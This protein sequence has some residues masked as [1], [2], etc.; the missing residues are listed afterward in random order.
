MST[1]QFNN[2]TLP[3]QQKIVCTNV[4]YPTDDIYKIIEKV[5]EI[6]K[7]LYGIIILL[8]GNSRIAVLT[9]KQVPEKTIKTAYRIIDE[10]NIED[11]LTIV[12]FPK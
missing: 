9:S 12:P 3:F 1:N 4:P 2:D 5:S 6:F 11:T 8:Y 10:N 7:N